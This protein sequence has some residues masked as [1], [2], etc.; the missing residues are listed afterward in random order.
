MGRAS[1]RRAAIGA[2]AGPASR[3]EYEAEAAERGES[4][5]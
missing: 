3:E 4:L 5:F 1:G 2:Q